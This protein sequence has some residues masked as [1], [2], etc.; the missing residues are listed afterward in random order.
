MTVSGLPDARFVEKTM[1]LGDF[2]D[3]LTTS[4]RIFRHSA[5]GQATIERLADR[6]IDGE[7]ATAL[8]APMIEQ[9]KDMF[10]VDSVERLKNRLKAWAPS[11]AESIH[12]YNTHGCRVLNQE[13]ADALIVDYAN[14]ACTPLD[15]A[16]L[17][18][19]LKR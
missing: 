18:S 5:T 13:T 12:G 10:D 6:S 8:I 1:N 19:D 3:M 11:A 14:A 7:L 2:A 9:C 16:M 4:A 17:T 15:L